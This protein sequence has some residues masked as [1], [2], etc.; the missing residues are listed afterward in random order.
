MEA[1]TSD[2][3]LYANPGCSAC[4]PTLQNIYILPVFHPLM[5]YVTTSEGSDTPPNPT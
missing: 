2:L 4:T 3:G 1:Q 5:K